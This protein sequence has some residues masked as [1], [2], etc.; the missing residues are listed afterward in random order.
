MEEQLSRTKYERC[1]EENSKNYRNGTSTKTVRS[2]YGSVE[3]E[4]LH[5]R[6]I[7]YNEF[8]SHF[9]KI[10]SELSVLSKM[11][12]VKTAE[13]FSKSRDNTAI[14]CLHNIVLGILGNH[15]LLRI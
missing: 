1:S 2:S 12:S 11:I 14:Y 4:I 8:V 15:G 5:N 13:M 6:N 7:E 10:W 9:K 3:L